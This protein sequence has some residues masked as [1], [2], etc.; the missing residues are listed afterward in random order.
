MPSASVSCSAIGPVEV[1]EEGGKLLAVLFPHLSGLRMHQVED[2]A[3]AVVISVSS[4]ASPARC[5]RCGAASSRV[6]GGYWRFVADG[7]TG[8]RPVLSWD[9]PG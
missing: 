2:T 5:P 3:D 9:L 6:H 8:V 1:S 4:V 7:A